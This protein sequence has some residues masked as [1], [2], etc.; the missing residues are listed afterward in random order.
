MKDVR[1][2]G[3]CLSEQFAEYLSAGESEWSPKLDYYVRLVGRLTKS[4]QGKKPF[5][6]M[7]W[8]FNE[9][10]NENSHALYVTCIE[11]MGV[12]CRDPAEVSLQ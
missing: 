5:P 9:F 10:P 6:F 2:P 8:R 7:D 3:W 11:I 12:P 1:P 4:M